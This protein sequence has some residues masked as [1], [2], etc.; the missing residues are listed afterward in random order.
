MRSKLVIWG[1]SGHA[2]IVADIV[3][4]QGE[5]EI[6]GF[7]DDVNL[8]RHGTE[9]CGAPI[10]GGREQLDSLQHLGV[11]CLIFG[12]GD[13]DARLR[14]SALVRAKGFS[15]ITAIHPQAI[16]ASDVT[17]G[18]GTVIGAAAVIDPETKLGENVIVNSLAFIG[19]E[20]IIEDGAHIGPGARLAGRVTIGRG[21]WV[22]IGT[23]VRERVF[24]GRHTLIGAGAVVLDDIPDGVVAYGVPARVIR[25]VIPNE[26]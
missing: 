10:L 23:T 20:S 22:G 6:V 21:T 12:F 18:A 25:K 16:V 2:L 17:I 1:A 5:Y 4:L 15:L 26:P 7:L 3:R 13:C 24:I 9:F 19:H 8:E 14:W 11:Q